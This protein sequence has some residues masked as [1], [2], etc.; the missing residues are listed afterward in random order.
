MSRRRRQSAPV[1]TPRAR[2]VL[3]RAPR[4][5]RRSTVDRDVNEIILHCS[6][7]R[8]GQHIDVD[9]IRR[10]HVQGN[11]WSDIGYHFVVY[12]DGTVVPGRPLH[13]SGAHVRGRNK[14]S[15]GICYIGGCEADGKTPKDTMTQEQELSVRNLVVALRASHGDLALRGHNEFASKACPSFQVADKFCD[16]L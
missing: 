3:T 7:T 9:T 13:R 4:T 12:L 11:G 5:T 6:A 10:W 14:A 16:I 8:E 15:I 2:P 1:C